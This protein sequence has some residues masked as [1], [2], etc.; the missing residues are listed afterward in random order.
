MGTDCKFFIVTGQHCRHFRTLLKKHPLFMKISLTRFFRKYPLI[1]TMAVAVLFIFAQAVFSYCTKICPAFNDRYFDEWFP[2]K[3]GQQ[4]VFSY[5]SSADTITI[6]DV[7]KSSEKK[8]SV[9]Y[10]S[11]PCLM[12][13]SIRSAEKSNNLN[14][15]FVLQGYID[16]EK[17]Y[18]LHLKSLKLDGFISG[19]SGLVLPPGRYNPDGNKYLFEHQRNQIFNGMLYRKIEIITIDTGIAKTEGIYKLWIAARYGIIGYEEYPS[20]KRWA[21]Q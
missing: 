9:G 1:S 18:S 6:A 15:D 20:L 11:R 3:K 2:Y 14:P 7:S 12:E 8:V 17:N 16:N 4:L 5:G 13:V 21:K 19:D 10:G